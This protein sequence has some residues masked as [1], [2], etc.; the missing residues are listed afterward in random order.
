MPKILMAR[1]LQGLYPID[2]AGE[3]VI[4][5]FGAGEVVA[6]DVKRPRNI[7][8]HAKFFAMLN[9]ILKNQEHYK[10]IDDLLE[11]CKLRVGHC[12]TVQT[13]LGE[14]KITDS[15]RFASMDETAFDDFYDRACAW[16]VSEVIPG[17]DRGH[18]D[19]EVRAEL[20]G[21]GQPEG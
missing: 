20:L 9:I 14:V 15:I 2:E 1:K 12:H 13:R 5:K 11:V 8:F 6:I 21:F 16:V 3:A 7:K 4:R 10:S 17:L 18:L 19:E